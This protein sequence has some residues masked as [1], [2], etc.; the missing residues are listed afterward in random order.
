MCVQ[1]PRTGGATACTAASPHI[2]LCDSIRYR[3]ITPMQPSQATFTVR[4]IPFRRPDSKSARVH[5]RS[6]MRPARLLPG[7]GSPGTVPKGRPSFAGTGWPRLGAGGVGS[8]LSAAGT[9]ERAVMKR[10][11][12]SRVVNPSVIP[13]GTGHKYSRSSISAEGTAGNSPG[14]H[15]W[16]SGARAD[17]RSPESRRDG[18]GCTGWM[19]RRPYGT[20]L[21][22]IVPSNPGLRKAPSWAIPRRPL[23]DSGA[24]LTQQ[25]CSCTNQLRLLD[26][27]NDPCIM[28]AVV[29][30]PPKLAGG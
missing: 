2:H 18:G 10:R 30:F 17:M 22:E 20:R 9:D 29:C 4:I 3:H 8:R 24:G 27:L 1:Y 16:G 21:V 13:A 14:I 19:F 11:G 26:S 12:L 23:R 5:E 25:N 28:D 15:S 6:R 7:L